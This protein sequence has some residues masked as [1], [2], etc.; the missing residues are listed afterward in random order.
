VFVN[1]PYGSR[2]GQSNQ[3]LWSARLLTEYAAG[4]VPEAVLLVNA[5]PAEG[6]F[7]PLWRYAL[8][9]T[10]HRI[11]FDGPDGGSSSPT[12]SNVFVYL[13]PQT[14]AFQRLFLPLGTVVL[15]D[16]VAGRA[17]DPACRAKGCY[18]VVAD[19]PATDDEDA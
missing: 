7:Q 18:L 6:W 5:V 1:P 15:G 19:D 4:R 9:F 8:C 14:A 16:A 11:H 12:H 10:N 17:L 2:D 13:G 3:R